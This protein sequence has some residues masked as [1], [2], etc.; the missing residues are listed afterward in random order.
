MA[1]PLMLPL[2]AGALMAGPVMAGA[3]SGREFDAS[4]HIPKTPIDNLT[5][6]MR[7]YAGLSGDVVMTNEGLIYG[8]APGELARPLFGFLSILDIKVTQQLP[9]LFK[10]EQKEAMVYTDPAS[11]GLLS[12]WQNVY[13]DETLIPV[14]YVSPNNTY[15]F[16]VTGSYSRSLPP[17]RSGQFK[18][19]WRASDTDIWVT[20]SRFNTYPSIITASEFPKAYSGPMRKSVDVLTFRGKAHDFA[21]QTAQF[22]PSEL[23]MMSDAPWPLWMMMGARAGGVLWH[24]FGQK[25]R[26]MQDLPRSLK[27]PIEA[28]YPSFLAD[29]WGFPSDQWGTA[30]QM[31]RLRWEGKL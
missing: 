9:E 19:N 1:V 3:R 6:F 15:F 26:T 21:D 29:P 14:G 20:E 28:A 7:L 12:S 18:L 11:G 23:T 13:T 8:K 25:Y 4:G 16:D 2:M 24:G 27:G 17:T 30:A 5:G 31:R 22:M 10:A